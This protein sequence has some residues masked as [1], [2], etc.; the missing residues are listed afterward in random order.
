MASRLEIPTGT[1]F[2]RLTVLSEMEKSKSGHRRFRLRC[3]C[4]NETVALLLNLRKKKHTTSCG[5]AVQ[6]IITKHGMAGSATYKVWVGLRTRCR[7]PNDTSFRNYGGRGL[8]VHPRWTDFA[9]FLADMGE[10]PPGMDL[11]RIDNDR[12]YEP[13]NCRWV[14]RKIN[15][16]NTRRTRLVVLDGVL[17]TATQASETLGLPRCKIASHVFHKGGTHQEAVDYFAAKRHG[18]KG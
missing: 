8:T 16:Q 14:T 9:A 6:E 11:D 5:C 10:R 2:G 17:M 1:V 7:N 12:G 15:L 13:G 18:S 4:G 3:L